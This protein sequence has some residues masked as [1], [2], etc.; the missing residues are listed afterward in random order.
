MILCTT[1][2]QTTCQKRLQR[3]QKAAAGLVLGRYVS[4]EDILLTL[5]WLPVKHQREWNLLKTTHKVI[6]N[7]NWPNYLK[8]NIFKH[9][10]C[11]RSRIEFIF[12][13]KENITRLLEYKVLHKR[14]RCWGIGVGGFGGAVVRALAFHL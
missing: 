5:K 9:S 7:T 6:H 13:Q 2:S 10:K 12:T 3:V 11:L 4:T 1:L 8:L 14:E